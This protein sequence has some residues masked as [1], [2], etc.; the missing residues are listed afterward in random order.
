L[1]F[2]VYATDAFNDAE[3]G[4]AFLSGGEDPTGVGTWI[5]VSAAEVP[6]PARTQVTIPIVITV[7]EGAR[8]GD[9]VGAILAAN[10]ARSTSDDGSEVVLDRRTGARVNIRVNGPVTPEL[11]IADVQTDYNG[12]IN[13]LAG[14]AS[15]SYTFENRGN[16]R[17]SGT[18]RVT[19]SGPFGLAEQRSLEREVKDLLPGQSLT[20][21]EVFDGVPAT[22]V[23]ITKVSIE[24]A[25]SNVDEVGAVSRSTLTLAVPITLLLVILALFFGWLARRAYRRHRDRAS[26][27]PDAMNVDE[28][29]EL[30]ES[31]P[32]PT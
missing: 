16:V 25:S 6:V 8:P 3:G 23:I 22:G 31:E 17:I 13:P 21:Q 2:Q 4:I 28:L 12:S 9:H 26:I 5:A 20:L 24:P 29:G 19:V 32:Q 18:A 10:A 27:V 7:P 15:V 14:T 11:A 1:V 30:S